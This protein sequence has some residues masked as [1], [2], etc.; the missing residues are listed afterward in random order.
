MC[1]A[2]CAGWPSVLIIV[3]KI[4]SYSMATSVIQAFPKKT[5]KKKKAS[6]ICLFRA[7]QAVKAPGD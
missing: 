2:K 3:G 7:E 6:T 5:T 4:M 1:F